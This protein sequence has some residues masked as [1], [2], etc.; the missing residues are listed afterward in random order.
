MA[1]S[2]DEQGRLDDD[3]LAITERVPATLEAT[4]KK[5]EVEALTIKR[6]FHVNQQINALR[7]PE[8]PDGILASLSKREYSRI[9]Y[10][11]KAPEE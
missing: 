10:R 9:T 11:P 8:S 5:F 4:L 3:Q 2:E 1:L 6:G 7:V